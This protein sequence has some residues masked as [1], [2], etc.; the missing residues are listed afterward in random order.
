MSNE[1]VE[2]GRLFEPINRIAD[3]ISPAKQDRFINLPG[4]RGYWPMS[5]V[6]FT[7]EAVDHSN[8]S[9]NLGRIGAPT[10]SYDGNGYVQ[11]GVATD[12]LSGSV[13]AQRVTGLETWIATGKKGLTLGGWV[14]ADTQPA[15]VGGI[16]TIYGVAGTRSYAMFLN[17]SQQVVFGVSNDGTAVI[18]VT[19]AAISL[20]GWVWLVGRF[21]PGS[22]LAIFVNGV[23]VVNTTTIPASAFISTVP[24]EI[25]RISANNAQ[26]LEGKFRDMFLCAAI[27]PDSLIEETRASTLPHSA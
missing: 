2:I 11:C 22:E 3:A 12:Y 7:G 15:T 16:A 10:F 4:L 18:N 17:S 21:T 24:F 19:S 23:K 9:S 6:N 5:V 27:L 8:A 13:S 1:N 20:G 25:G 26:I 14:K